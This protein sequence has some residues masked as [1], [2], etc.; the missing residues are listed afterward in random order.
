MATKLKL[1]V[2]TKL[3]AVLRGGTGI[4]VTKDG[5]VY[6][7]D[8]DYS[9]LVQLTAPD[10]AQSMVAIW[11]RSTGLWN[12][13]SLST[14]LNG[15]SDISQDTTSS[16]DTINDGTTLMTIH[17]TAPTATA[18]QIPSIF[19]QGGAK[20]SIVDYSTSIAA[21]HVITLTPPGGSGS[22]I[23]GKTSWQIFS[24]ATQPGSLTLF[25]NTAL[26]DW[27]IAP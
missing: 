14:I 16:S 11:N 1:K 2:R 19:E 3:P 17:R 25:P 7:L 8:L 24:T 13:V 4:A 20:L 27:Y 9:R 12:V 18:L 22:K 23:M 21:D 10:G 15:V 6:T 5:L 26:N